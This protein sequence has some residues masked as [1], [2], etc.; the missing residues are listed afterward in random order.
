MECQDLIVLLYSSVL[1]EKHQITPRD[2]A[3]HEVCVT[4]SFVETV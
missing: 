2:R 1:Q 4:L 3:D